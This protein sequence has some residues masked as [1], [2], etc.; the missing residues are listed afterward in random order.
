MNCLLQRLRRAQLQAS[1]DLQY[2]VAKN[3]HSALSRAEVIHSILKNAG[4]SKAKDDLSADIVLL[5]TCA[6]RE[7]RER[8][9][10]SEF[11]SQRTRNVPALR[12]SR[13]DSS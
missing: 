2:Q 3:S 11:G 13:M 1:E 9:L 7:V 10:Q 8:P 5:N 4:Y 12:T 6:I